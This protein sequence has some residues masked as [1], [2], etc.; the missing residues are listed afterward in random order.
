MVLL[1]LSGHKK[2]LTKILKNL[3]GLYSSFSSEVVSV[4]IEFL[5]N[6]ISSAHVVDPSVDTEV[7]RS[8][9]TLLNEWK[10]VIT[11]FTNKE[12][13]LLFT[14]LKTVLHMIET[15]DTIE[16]ETGDCHPTCVQFSCIYI[17]GSL[18]VCA[19]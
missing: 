4:L 7:C 2:E 16:N 14:L 12:P 19:C 3:A 10:L 11:I 17:C 1:S 13:D 6:T 18:C 8:I 15:Q 5:L 9:D